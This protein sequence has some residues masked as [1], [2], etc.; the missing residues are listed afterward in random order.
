MASVVFDSS[1]GI[2]GLSVQERFRRGFWSAILAGALVTVAVHV[3]LDLLGLAV[4]MGLIP[5]EGDAANEDARA[6]GIGAAIW[7][8]A[9]TI[10]AVGVG[11]FVTGRLASTPFKGRGALLGV[12]SWALSTVLWITATTLFLGGTLAGAFGVLNQTQQML[13]GAPTVTAGEADGLRGSGEQNGKQNG[14]REAAERMAPTAQD[15]KNAAKAAST[16]ALWA[17][18]GLLLSAGAGCG[19]AILGAKQNAKEEALV[20]E[21][22]RSERTD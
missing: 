5:P 6:V 2:V 15:A 18:L 7:W 10:I 17:F 3:M 11:A 19:G 8:L 14:L 16:A 20:P 21:P 4:G 9:T 13:Q 22:P 12:S 1:T